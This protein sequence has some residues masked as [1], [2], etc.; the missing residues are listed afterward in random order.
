M[1]PY[2]VCVCG[3]SSSNNLNSFVPLRNLKLYL[4]QHILLILSIDLYHLHICNVVMVNSHW[5]IAI[6]T[7]LFLN[8]NNRSQSLSG[9]KT[10]LFH[11][12]ILTTCV[13][14]LLSVG[15]PGWTVWG[16]GDGRPPV[17]G[18][19]HPSQNRRGFWGR[20]L[21]RSETHARRLERCWGTL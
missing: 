2:H 7:S 14:C 9:N 15:V 11:S 6:A 1:L 5:A 13:D 4:L 20:R 8:V 12:A 19:V 10:S 18:S 21:V 17:D 3:Q 16:S